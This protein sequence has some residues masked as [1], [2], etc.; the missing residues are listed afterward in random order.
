MCG[1]FT[2]MATWAQVADFSAP[3]ASRPS[4]APE[5]TAMPMRL[6]T[7]AP[8]QLTGLGRPAMATSASPGLCGWPVD[9]SM[10]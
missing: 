9:G 5:E 4:N 2:Y 8:A 6:Q 10:R 1:K 7:V 3:L